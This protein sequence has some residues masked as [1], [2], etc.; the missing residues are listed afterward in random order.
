MEENKNK[1]IIDLRELWKKVRERKRLFF[2]TL[3]LAFVLSCL[4]IICIPRYYDTDVRLAPELENPMS[5]GALGSLAASFG[6]DLSNMESSDAIS[7]MLYP[8]LMSD[9]GF[10]SKFFDFKVVSADGEINTNYHDYLRYQQ[11]QPWWGY[12][13][14]SLKKL[15]P[16]KKEEGIAGG[17][18]KFNPYVLSRDEDGVIKKIQNNVQFNMDKKT[19]VITIMVRDQ[20]R[21]ICKTVADSVRSLLQQFITDYR[22]SKARNDLKYYTKLA[23]DAKQDYERARQLYG[24][25][26]DRNMDVVLESYR[27]KQEDLENDMQLKFNT[28]TA[29]QTQLQQAKA[30]VQERTP[31]FTLLKGASVP[32]KP[33]GPKRMIFVIGMVFLTFLCT[34]GY[35]LKGELWKF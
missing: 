5:G 16:K 4:F 30:K 14:D 24:S 7:P 25:Y 27:A 10:V 21:L 26:S 32:I 33:S 28:Y 9:N 35:I 6:F 20:D 15:L 12:V 18:D 19:G 22:T 31:A 13:F 17:D 29:M 1:D 2:I 3:P 34:L 11:K 23:V 8:D